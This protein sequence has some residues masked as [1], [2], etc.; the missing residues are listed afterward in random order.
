RSAQQRLHLELALVHMARAGEI[1]PVAE[2]GPSPAGSGGS[3]AEGGRKRSFTPSEKPERFSSSKEDTEAPRDLSAPPAFEGIETPMETWEQLVE[4]INGRA[5]AIGS[6]LEQLIPRNV[7]GEEVVIGGKRGEIYLEVLQEK[8][9]L[10][11]LKALLREFF[12][13]DMRVKF[14]EMEA[15]ERARNHNVIE[16]REQRESDLER[17]IKKETRDHPMVR[18]AM[19][20]FGGELKSVKVLGKSTKDPEDMPPKEEE[21]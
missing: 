6:M 2:G 4:F 10:S 3:G 12:N 19:E 14:V 13:R 21:L 20:I 17:K 15:K 16:K 5:P 8:E 1:V 18:E 11:E 7:A 9:K